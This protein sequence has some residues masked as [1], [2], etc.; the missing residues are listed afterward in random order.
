MPEAIRR[1][2]ISMPFFVLLFI[3]WRNIYSRKLR[4]ALTIMGVVI[5]ISSIFFLASIGLGLQNLVTGEILGSQSVK[6][7]DVTSQNSELLK[8]DKTIAAKLSQL[9]GVD[10][11]GRSYSYA[12]ILKLD[13]SE[14]DSVVYGI[15][16]TYQELSNLNLLKGRLLQDNDTKSAFLNKA[17]LDSMGVKS[18]EDILDKSLNLTIDLDLEDNKNSQLTGTYQV[19][20]VID[21]GSGSEVFI[22][23]NQFDSVEIKQYNQIR[24]TAD[25]NSSINN[26]RKQIESMGLSTSSPLDTINQVNQIFHYF[27][28]ILVS[29]GAIGMIV[30]LLG[31]FNTLTIS[32]LE[33]TREIALMIVLGARAR[34]MRKLFMLE[35]TILALMGSFIG[36]LLAQLAGYA[37]NIGMNRMASGRG[38]KESFVVTSA[39]WWLYVSLI[40]FMVLMGLLITLIPAHRASKI[41]PIDALRSE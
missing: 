8:L 15:D 37:V 28:I 11:I 40:I 18:P 32:L 5:G 29:L 9:G 41:N 23:I 19:V 1:R 25:P 3:G 2:F 22:P 7:I 17:A 26:L 34:D 13:N 30:A 33:R 10:K 4:S 20:G 6:S 14:T 12:G 16:T 35:A 24:L 31:M 36:I 39:P 38:V 27:N 21:S